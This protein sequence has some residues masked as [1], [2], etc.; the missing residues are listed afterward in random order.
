MFSTFFIKRPRF[1]MVIAVILM[2][3]GAIAAFNLP[4]KQYPDVAPPQISVSASF[5]GADAETVANTVGVPLEEA[6]NGVDGMIYMSS[7]ASNTG[8]YSLTITFKTGTNPDM[9]LVKV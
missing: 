4:V 3:A 5:P 8:R 6:L 2:L 1:A 7:T 9:A